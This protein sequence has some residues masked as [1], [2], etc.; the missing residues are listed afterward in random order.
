MVYVRATSYVTG[1]PTV[2]LPRARTIN[3]Q[4]AGGE[5][6]RGAAAL[7]ARV[8]GVY[9]VR[10]RVLW[11]WC[12]WRCAAEYLHTHAYIRART[13]NFAPL[14]EMCVSSVWC[15]PHTTLHRHV[16]Y[17]AAAAAAEA[18]RRQSQSASSTEQPQPQQ[19][20]LTSR[21]IPFAHV[22]ARHK[23]LTN[24]A[25]FSSVVVTARALCSPRCPQQ[26]QILQA[27]RTDPPPHPHTSLP[28]SN[29]FITRYISIICVCVCV[30]LLYL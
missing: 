9:R 1:Y 10:A 26:I 14:L 15:G 24:C 25:T 12:W 13:T 28:R 16:A 18:D 30:Y 2:V 29:I 8:R 19:R 3:L 21:S 11:C 4:H 6:W 27:Q 20:R 5:L 7:Y 17:A 23:L 22:C